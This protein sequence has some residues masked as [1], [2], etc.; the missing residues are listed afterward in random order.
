[1]AEKFD[2]QTFVEAIKSL[3]AD[4]Q[5][6]ATH[7]EFERVASI[8]VRE[9]SWKFRQQVYL[10]RLE[11]LGKFLRGEDVSSGLT[12]SE[13][14]AYALLGPPAPP[15]AGPRVPAPAAPGSAGRPAPAAPAKAAPAGAE[16]RRSTR[17]KMRTRARIRRESGDAFEVLEP[18]NVSKGGISFRSAQSYE[19]KDAVL[20]NM[21]YQPGQPESS[22]LERRGVVVRKTPV[23]VPGQFLYGL[24]FES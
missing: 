1:M 9:P 18:S 10:K 4:L 11:R 15:I 12:P 17:I 16:R 22:G 5:E 8:V 14:E 6:Q 13:A 21:H 3:G 24:E 7:E 19:L 2:F 20:V 23:N